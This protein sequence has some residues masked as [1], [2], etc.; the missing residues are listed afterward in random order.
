MKIFRTNVSLINGD[1]NQYTEK[2][3]YFGTKFN[4]CLFFKFKGI[5]TLL[6]TDILLKYFPTRRNKNTVLLTP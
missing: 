2:S 3:C 4:Q 5:L 6:K 1:W